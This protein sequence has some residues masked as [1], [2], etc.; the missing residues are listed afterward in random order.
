MLIL[1][2]VIGEEL[3]TIAVIY[4]PNQDTPIF[5]ENLLNILSENMNNPMIICGDFNLTLNFSLD[6]SG[7]LRENN[8]KS[9]QKVL[10]IM[11]ILELVDTWRVTN[12][13]ERKFTYYSSN[14]PLKISRLDFFLVTP[15]IHA[16]VIKT[17][18]SYG[19]RTDHSFVG[20][21][22]DLCEAARGKGFWKFN[23]ALLRDKDYINLVKKV[24]QNVI[25]R[26]TNVNQ[27]NNESS[28]T[29]SN[30]MLWE[31]IKLG[32][33]GETIPYCIQRKKKLDKEESELEHRIREL[34]DC[35]NA[36]CN[37]ANMALT[38]ITE[39]EKL[40]QNL[41]ILRENKLNGSLIRSK[42]KIYESMGKPSTLFCNLEKRNYTKK[43]VN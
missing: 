36:G 7:Y 28:Q 14:R 9:K 43:L 5:Y 4:G 2:I 10:E 18:L 13:T 30:Q 16:K 31:M 27:D 39:K 22:V 11:E 25:E 42:A 32:I 29:I 33:R 40:K 23:T 34:D 41:E 24:I 8:I 6:A 37:S 38:L 1:N 15:D 17:Y 12:P 3:I 21:S 19:Y 26:Y 20:I 35:L